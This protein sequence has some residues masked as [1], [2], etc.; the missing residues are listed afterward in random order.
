LD[1]GQFDL[2]AELVLQQ[3]RDDVGAGL[4]PHPGVDRDLD[5]PRRAR[6]GRAGLRGGGGGG[7]LNRGSAAA[8][9]GEADGQKACEQANLQLNFL[10][11]GEGRLSAPWVRR[12]RRTPGSTGAMPGMK[13][14]PKPAR[15]ENPTTTSYPSAPA[16]TR[17]PTTTMASVITMPWLAA[18]RIARLA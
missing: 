11:R 3:V 12:S 4:V 15:G 10:V 7:G 1:L 14:M 13:P 9:S 6:A 5:G 16:P 17:P 2:V 8:H 18:S